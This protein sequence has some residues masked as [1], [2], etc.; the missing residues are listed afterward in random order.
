M[1]HAV[2][3]LREQQDAIQIVKSTLPVL[4]DQLTE[5]LVT[6]ADHKLTLKDAKTL[7]ALNDGERLNYYE[8][9]RVMLKQRLQ[10]DFSSDDMTGKQ[11]GRTTAN[12]SVPTCEYNF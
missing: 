5:F 2:I 10:E 7:V 8:T 1:K 3:I 11:I 6:S 9:V 12:W 4:P